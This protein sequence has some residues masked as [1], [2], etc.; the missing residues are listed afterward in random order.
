M[1]RTGL[2][3]GLVHNHDA[4][5]AVSMTDLT[6]AIARH[7]HQVT[8]VAHPSDGLAPL[9]LTQLDLVAAAGGD[10]T[11]AA[12]AC[13][14]ARMSAPTPL[15]VL[16]MGTANNIALSLGVP[17]DVGEAIATWR[18]ATPRPFDLGIATG[19]W[20]E[21]QLVES[22]GGG[23]VTHGTVVM[24]RQDYTSPTTDAQ[25]TR[26]R[27]AHADVLALLAP[28]PWRLVLDE[29]PIEGEF[30]LVEVMNIAAV[31]PNLVL[32]TDASPWDARFTVVA[33]TPDHREALGAWLRDGGTVAP[34]ED[35]LVWHAHEVRIDAGDRL[36]VDDDVMEGAGAEGVSL[37]MAPGAIAV[38]A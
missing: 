5:D 6:R 37:R 11:I 10:G 27:H 34:P 13:A 30:L 17:T 33:A 20:G 12:T 14:L 24:E 38:L 2:R 36:H 8:G 35:L 26:A 18:R 1:R 3:V 4:G 22:L 9:D 31:G 25:L 19:P 15:A 16:P 29:R 28:C 21:R 7:G 32:T 23:L